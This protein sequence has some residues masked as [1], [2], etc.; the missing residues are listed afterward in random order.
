M[1]A[2]HRRASLCRS[3]PGW[4]SCS[5]HPDDSCPSRCAFPRIHHTP[6][7]QQ[8]STALCSVH[9]LT[10]WIFP[11]YSNHP[12]SLSPKCKKGC[13][14]SLFFLSPSES[15][16]C[17]S[18]FF[19]LLPLFISLPR[20]TEKGPPP[21]DLAF[22]SWHETWLGSWLGITFQFYP[23][24]CPRSLDLQLHTLKLCIRLASHKWQ[25]NLFCMY[26]HRQN[27]RCEVSGLNIHMAC[28]TPGC[29]HYNRPSPKEGGLYQLL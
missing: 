8:S 6:A 17:F 7:R 19:S 3:L 21:A 12:N 29:L 28:V 5:P 11:N 27:K 1:T 23:P 22:R 18:S 15:I 14:S 20:F 16:C 9:S 4:L 24:S 13:L 26:S 10:S 25:P 2:E